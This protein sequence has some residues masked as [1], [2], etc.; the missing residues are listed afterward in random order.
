[1]ATDGYE[2]TVTSLV[3]GTACPSLQF[4]ISSYVI[5]TAASTQFIGGSCANIKAGTKLTSLDGTRPDMNELVLYATQITIGSGQST[6]T[7][8]P[9]PTPTPTPVQADVTVS[10]IVSGTD[11]PYLQFMVSNYVLQLASA[12]HYT[13]GACAD[14]KAGV[15]ARI[16]GTKR[17]SDGFI[18]V[19][20]LGFLR[21]GSTPEP[22]SKSPTTPTPTPTPAPTL[23]SNTFEGVVDE[24]VSGA[25]CP[26]MQFTI[27]DHTFTTSR[28]TQYEHGGC[29]D[30][31]PGVS[32]AVAGTRRDEKG[33]LVSKLAFKRSS[34]N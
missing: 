7:P 1:M 21:D 33:V 5:K 6:P 3:S 8:T 20:A 34:E 30:L 12:T 2:Y 24:L 29:G 15:K 22:P 13:G 11:C 9:A 14:V 10:S 32:V 25:T 27:D 26:Y 16:T 31:Q 19:T 18:V 17:E 4:M 23:E 28:M